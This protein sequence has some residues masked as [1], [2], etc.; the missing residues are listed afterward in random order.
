MEAGEAQAE[1]EDGPL[2]VDGSIVLCVVRNTRWDA[3][4]VDGVPDD[5]N[6]DGGA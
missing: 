4:R 1:G 3:R 6:S 2:F 5:D